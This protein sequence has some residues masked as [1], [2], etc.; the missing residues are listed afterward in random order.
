[1]CRKLNVLLAFANPEESTPLSLG[2]EH[3]AIREAIR[4]GRCRDGIHVTAI[5]AMTV[6]ALRRAFLDRRYHLV[7]MGGHG[8]RDGRP[9]AETAD[10]DRYP[11]PAQALADLFRD[12]TPPL[13]C[14]TLNECFSATAAALIASSVPVVIGMEN[15]IVD[16]DGLKFAEGFFDAIG[17]GRDADA[18]YE[19]GRRA[20]KL[21]SPD[22]D[23]QPALLRRAGS[24]VAEELTVVIRTAD[25]DHALRIRPQAEVRR[26]LEQAK[27]ATGVEESGVAGPSTRFPLKWALVDTRAEDYWDM[28]PDD[29]KADMLLLVE[30]NGPSVSRRGSDRLQDFG[31]VNGTTFRLYPAR[32]PERKIL[33]EDFKF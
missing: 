32:D 30:A 31:V 6:D 4:R 8:T 10:G 13:E 22:T 2:P 28:L 29:E 11:I 15:A 17:A 7:H 3:E 20:V 23:F 18:A 19:E 21:V 27:C 5:Q 14:V 25:G 9:I 12:Y 26:L 16:A 1:M 24:D 33:P